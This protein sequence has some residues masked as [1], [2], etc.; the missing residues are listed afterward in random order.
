MARSLF[1]LLL[2]LSFAGPSFG[3]EAE[4][5][6]EEMHDDVSPGRGPAHAH[7]ELTGREANGR[8]KRGVLSKTPASAFRPDARP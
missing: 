8:I 5:T 7:P 1:P 3:Q 4:T 6:P 2:A